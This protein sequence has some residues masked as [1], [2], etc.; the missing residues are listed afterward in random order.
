[1]ILTMVFKSGLTLRDEEKR[2]TKTQ[3]S[4]R[5]REFDVNKTLDGV[6]GVSRLAKYKQVTMK[7]KTKNG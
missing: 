1:M 4:R 7:F 2:T 6:F 5:N 3:S